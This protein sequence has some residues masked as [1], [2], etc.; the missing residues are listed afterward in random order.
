MKFIFAI[1]IIFAGSTS[2]AAAP[3]LN[4][5][6]SCEDGGTLE[7]EFIEDGVYYASLNYDN[8]DSSVLD[9]IDFAGSSSQGTMYPDDEGTVGVAIVNGATGTSVTLQFDSSDKLNCKHKTLSS[10]VEEI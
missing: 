9:K 5:Q 4:G 8:G 7:L 10:I 1:G 6:Y 2:M 3:L